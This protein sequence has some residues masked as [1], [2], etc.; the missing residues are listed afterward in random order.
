MVNNRARVV[1]ML[2]FSFTSADASGD[3]KGHETFGGGPSLF[4]LREMV[5][6]VVPRYREAVAAIAESGGSE[7]PELIRYRKPFTGLQL[8][9]NS[10]KN[11]YT[12][13][14]DIVHDLAGFQ[15][16]GHEGTFDSALA[17]LV[18]DAG[19]LF[20]RA[21]HFYDAGA[22]QQVEFGVAPHQQTLARVLYAADRLATLH[23]S[24]QQYEFRVHVTYYTL[25]NNEWTRRVA[26]NVLLYARDSGGDPLHPYPTLYDR[27]RFIGPQQLSAI[28]V[29]DTASSTTALSTM[30][31]RFAQVL[32]EGATALIARPLDGC[33]LASWYDGA[34][35]FV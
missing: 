23:D 35:H 20:I 16:T 8:T 27:S 26:T 15:I 4:M 33:S 32:P 29:A 25:V 28:D 14:Y 6:Q 3:T 30:Q 5:R 31:R 34:F 12:L 17:D 9:L 2:T 10:T 21:M 7:H 22:W 19:I 18:A 11:W 1:G 13:P 24:S